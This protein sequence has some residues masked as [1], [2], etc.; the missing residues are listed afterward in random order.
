L[1]RGLAKQEGYLNTV[2]VF[3]FV[4]VFAV[5]GL[6]PMPPEGG[7]PLTVFASQTTLS[8]KGRGN[9]TTAKRKKAHIDSAHSR[10]MTNPPVIVHEYAFFLFFYFGL[11][12][13]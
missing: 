4:F 13:K 7:R 9:T 2:V 12:T 8:L 5:I 3:L 6:R 11:S 1:K 10:R